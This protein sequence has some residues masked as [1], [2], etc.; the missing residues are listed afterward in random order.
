M[1]KCPTPAA[2]AGS[3][4]SDNQNSLTARPRGP[5]LMQ[6]DQL[7]QKLAKANLLKR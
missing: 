2:T 7:V 3:P 5:M 1:S 4:V 6:G